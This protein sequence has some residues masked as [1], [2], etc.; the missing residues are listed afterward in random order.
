MKWGVK[1]VWALV[2]FCILIW[3]MATKVGS[4]CENSLSHMLMFCALFHR[5]LRFNTKSLHKQF[6][7]NFHVGLRVK[8]ADLVWYF[9][10]LRVSCAVPMMD[11]GVHGNQTE[12]VWWEAAYTTKKQVSSHYIFGSHSSHSHSLLGPLSTCDNCDHCL[13]WLPGNPFRDQLQLTLPMT[14]FPFTQPRRKVGLAGTCN[15]KGLLWTRH[16]TP[17]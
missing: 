4:C 14:S 3:V 2:M 16:I 13:S 7:P 6:L 5:I 10:L 11:L 8:Q 9:S 1:R 17:H 15:R 12:T